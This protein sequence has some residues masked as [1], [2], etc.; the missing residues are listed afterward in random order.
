[1][2]SWP[3]IS[4]N[5]VLT[6]TPLFPTERHET[7]TVKLVNIKQIDYLFI[8]CSVVGA[9]MDLILSINHKPS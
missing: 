5:I 2:Q 4:L 3:L 9:G 7:M 6:L 1:M 8:V